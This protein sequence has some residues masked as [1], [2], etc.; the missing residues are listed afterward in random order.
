MAPACMLTHAS[1]LLV[2]K[3]LY[4]GILLDLALAPP[5]VMAL[6]GG[7]PGL[8]DLASVD[9][10]LASGLAAVRS[11]PGDVSDLGLTFSA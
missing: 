1:G 7:R 5:L 10:G 8:D 2:G 6:Q 3:A 11:Y 9:P 4:E